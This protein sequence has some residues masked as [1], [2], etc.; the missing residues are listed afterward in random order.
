MLVGE[1][2]SLSC[3]SV[4]RSYNAYFVCGTPCILRMT[5]LYSVSSV[6]CLDE[7]R[8]NWNERGI[9][10]WWRNCRCCAGIFLNARSLTTKICHLAVDW[11]T[12]EYF[13]TW[14][15]LLRVHS[16]MTKE[17]Q[18]MT[19]LLENLK[20]SLASSVPFWHITQRYRVLAK[21]YL[22]SCLLLRQCSD[23]IFIDREDL[24][25][26]SKTLCVCCYLT[27]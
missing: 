11:E 2:L 12:S 14:W 22:S 4:H 27:G 7:R 17:T 24:I 6:K 15:D 1:Y 3:F 10:W 26:K 13:P 8:G 21:R 20:I 5:Q 9:S 19:R 23:R 16:S 18:N 25:M